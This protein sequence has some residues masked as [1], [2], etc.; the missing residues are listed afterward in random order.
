MVDQATL[1]NMLGSLREYHSITFIT[2]GLLSNTVDAGSGR[3]FVGVEIET[4]LTAATVLSFKGS[5][6]ESATAGTMLAV[7]TEQSDG[8]TA[9]AAYSFVPAATVGYYPLDAA[10]FNGLRHLTVISDQAGN[11]GKV[12]KL[13]SKPL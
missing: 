3:S 2:G 5:A 11:A 12:I 10:I 4:A 13:V 6:A 7:Q 1:D 8:A 9:T